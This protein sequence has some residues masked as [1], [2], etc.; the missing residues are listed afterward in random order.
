[1]AKVMGQPCFTRFTTAR[2]ARVSAAS[3]TKVPASGAGAVAP[4]WG[5]TAM[6][7][8]RPMR[9]VSI[10]TPRLS[11]PK[12]KGETMGQ[13]PK[14]QKGRAMKRPSPPSTRSKKSMA[15]AIWLRSAK[16]MESGFSVPEIWA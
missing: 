11:S 4:A 14:T 6:S 16:D 7:L 3:C 15:G 10:R 12:R 8:T 2:Q 9:L 5:A 1:M 13:P